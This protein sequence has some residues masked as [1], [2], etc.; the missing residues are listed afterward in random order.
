MNALQPFW[1]AL[2]LEPGL[3]G[4]IRRYLM[5]RPRDDGMAWKLLQ[6]TYYQDF[7]HL[8]KQHYLEHNDNIRRLAREQRREY[9]EFNVKEGW[10]PLCKFLGDSIP[11]TPFPFGNDTKEM[12]A[13]VSGLKAGMENTIKVNAMKILSI[14]VVAVGAFGAWYLKMKSKP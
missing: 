9:L 14:V 3:T 10:E 8:G 12:Q 6:H 13:L 4:I 7:R 2:Y 1:D 5:P 11:R